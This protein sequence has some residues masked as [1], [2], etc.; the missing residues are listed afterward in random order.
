MRLLAGPPPSCTCS[1]YPG[2]CCA[3]RPQCPLDTAGLTRSLSS[4]GGASVAPAAAAAATAILHAACRSCLAATCV[5]AAVAAEARQAFFILKQGGIAKDD[6]ADAAP[7]QVHRRPCHV[8]VRFCDA[9]A[10]HHRQ[11]RCCAAHQ[12]WKAYIWVQL[13]PRRPHR[14][15]QSANR[16]DHLI[17]HLG[18]HSP[19]HITFHE[20]DSIP[21]FPAP[22]ASRGLGAEGLMDTCS[23][24][25]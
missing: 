17:G 10:T 11:Q 14:P 9:D 4:A 21:A 5:A 23:N 18:A 25:S 20:I 1:T 19:N 24:C 15:Q 3:R 22:A 16:Q 6:S 2:L 7:A 12:L 13:L 8:R